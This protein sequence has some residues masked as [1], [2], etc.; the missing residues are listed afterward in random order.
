MRF[1]KAKKKYTNTEY[2]VGSPKGSNT[3]YV[4]WPHGGGFYLKIG[5]VIGRKPR[6]ICHVNK[7]ETAKQIAN[8]IEKG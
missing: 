8:L 2:W 4:I 1:K 5:H 7:I 3:H 6:N